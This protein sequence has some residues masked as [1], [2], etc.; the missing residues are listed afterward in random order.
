MNAPAAQPNLILPGTPVEDGFHLDTVLIGGNRVNLILPPKAI[1]DH[2]PTIWN[3]NLKRVDGAM[4]LVDG[5]ANTVAMA[6]AGSE[7]ATWALDMKAYIPAVDELERAHRLLK[8][9]TVKNWC[10]LRSGINLHAIPPAYPYTPEDPKQTTVELFRTGGAEAFEET[11][12]WTST[13]I[14]PGSGC[15]WYQDFR[16]GDQDYGHKS[17]ELRVRLLRRSP[18]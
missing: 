3:K 18:I 8:P 16:N 1:A 13:Q 2:A 9:G 14:G 12:Y 17:A 15:A 7:I 6:A 10:F 5:Y 4:S 11:A